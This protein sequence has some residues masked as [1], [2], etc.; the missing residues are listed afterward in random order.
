MDGQHSSEKPSSS[1]GSETHCTQK[2]LLVGN[3]PTAE[4][5]HLRGSQGWRQVERDRDRHCQTETERQR[6]VR[7]EVRLWPHQM[8]RPWGV[9]LTELRTC[10]R[11]CLHLKQTSGWGTK[12]R[13]PLQPAGLRWPLCWE[14]QNWAWATGLAR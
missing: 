3:L 7:S 12:T 10:E 11:D 1:Q 14:V 4:P 2:T 6:D 8:L 5:P 13:N 9:T